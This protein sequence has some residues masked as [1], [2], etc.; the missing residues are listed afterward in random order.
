MK[1]EIVAQYGWANMGI[2]Y[3]LFYLAVITRP[4]G[5]KS[6]LTTVKVSCLLFTP[7][8]NDDYE[9]DDEAFT[10]LCQ[11]FFWKIL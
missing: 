1:Q 4:V 10:H 11:I 2:L 9:K 6:V 3:M 7:V 5:F 8:W